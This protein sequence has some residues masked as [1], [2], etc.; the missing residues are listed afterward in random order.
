MRD[1]LF[2]GNRILCRIVFLSLF[3]NCRTSDGQILRDTST[4]TLI[5]KGIKCI[6]S[7]RINE[8]EDILN[9]L[10]ERYPGHPATYLYK[11]IMI[12]YRN[13]PLLASSPE[14]KSLEYQLKTS[15]RLC[16]TQDNWIDDPE[17]LLIDLCSRG[18]LLLF[19]NENG[20]SSD[21]IPI[22]LTT[23]K[24]IRKSFQFTSLYPDFSYFTGL[25]NYYR[26]VYPEHHAVY[27]AVALLFPPGESRKGLAELAYCAGNA[28]VL[29]AE[30]YSILSWINQYYEKNYSLALE[31]SKTLNDLYPSNLLFRGEYIKVLVLLKKYDEAER[32]ISSSVNDNNSYFHGQLDVFNGLIQEKKY[33]NYEMAESFYSK[34]LIIMEQ[35]GSRGKE[36]KQYGSKGLKRLKDLKSGKQVSRKK[37]DRDSQDVD[38]DLLEFN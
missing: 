31:Y 11:G 21:V 13:Y 10:N 19:Y 15:I 20:L 25:Y 35:F 28:I 34:G 6:Y 18:L 33:H 14:R 32:L 37:K 1:Y 36:F 29:K 27:R 2:S 30:A 23:Y 12:Y 17:K 38:V 8:A 5:R 16:E 26:E 24:G 9:R 3:L 22:V 4:I 7:I